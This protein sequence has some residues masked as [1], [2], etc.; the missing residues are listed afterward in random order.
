MM[1][2]DPDRHEDVLFGG[3]QCGTLTQG[4]TNYQDT[5]TWDGSAWNQR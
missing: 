3:F 1:A 4:C 2:Y 5:W